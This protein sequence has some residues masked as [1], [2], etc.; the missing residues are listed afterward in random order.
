VVTIPTGWEA[1][2]VKAVIWIG[3]SGAVVAILGLRIKDHVADPME[4]PLTAGFHPASRKV[5]QADCK[6]RFILEII[7]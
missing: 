3:I 1:D 6:S 4:L 2:T 7:T 5:T